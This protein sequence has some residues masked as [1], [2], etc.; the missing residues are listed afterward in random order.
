MKITMRE[1]AARHSYSTMSELWEEI[2]ESAEVR[3]AVE[4][5]IVKKFA[6]T[7]NVEEEEVREYFS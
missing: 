3:K 6:E 2:A 4:D 7:H 1:L 5:L